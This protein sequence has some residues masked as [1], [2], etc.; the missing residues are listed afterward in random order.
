VTTAARRDHLLN[1]PLL[2][3]G[4]FDRAIEL[5]PEAISSAPPVPPGPGGR[6]SWSSIPGRLQDDHSRIFVGAY[7]IRD[8]EIARGDLVKHRCKQEKVIAA[9]E[10]NLYRALSR[11][12]FLKMNSGINSAKTTAENDDSF[13]AP[14]AGYSDDHLSSF[15]CEPPMGRCEER[16]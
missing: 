13:F 8:L 4:G 14:P 5:H 3:I 9:N 2:N 12:Q 16:C 11:H 10:A 15:R 6:K 1:L 7:G